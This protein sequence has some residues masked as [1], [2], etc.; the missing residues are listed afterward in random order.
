VTAGVAANVPYHDADTARRV[1]DFA[2]RGLEQSA[3][4]AIVQTV[5]DAIVATLPELVDDAELQ[6]LLWAETESHWRSFLTE[7]W[8]GTNHVG[9]LNAT[10]ALTRV[11]A[12]RRGGPLR[13]VRAYMAAQT[14]AVKHVTCQVG[15]E[16]E[17]EN[18]LTV[19]LALRDRIAAWVESAIQMAGSAYAEEGRAWSGEAEARRAA[20]VRAILSGTESSTSR[21]TELLGYAVGLQQTA[22]IAWVDS[23]S[24]EDDPQGALTKLISHAAPPDQKRGKLTIEASRTAVWA[25]IASA[26][27]PDLGEFFAR[28]PRGMHVAVGESASGCA[29]M[30]SSHFQARAVHRLMLSGQ[31][32]RVARYRDVELPCLATGD[33]SL[34]VM[35]EIARRELGGLCSDDRSIARLRETALML[36]DLGSNIE[37]TAAAMVVHPNTIR[38]RMRRIEYHLGHPLTQRVG[39]FE[40]ALRCVQFL[41]TDWLLSA[42]HGRRSNP[43]R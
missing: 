9:P 21:A 10:F 34:E 41:G 2:A 22:L 28:V 24:A 1:A 38:Y 17:P 16:V 20:T 14:A 36:L 31:E 27:P 5:C 8:Q 18:R 25:W 40:L 37:A 35:R 11:T 4:E 39:A 33:G 26:T 3:C 43:D 30:R 6:R 42:S 12:R 7:A 29:G 32:H 23:D 15:T 19:L 13:I